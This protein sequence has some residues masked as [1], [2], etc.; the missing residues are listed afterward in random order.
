MTKTY[1]L[2]DFKSRS[3]DVQYETLDAN[4]SKTWR[5]KPS[6]KEMPI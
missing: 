1:T 6:K 3:Q 2:A 5:W 4:K